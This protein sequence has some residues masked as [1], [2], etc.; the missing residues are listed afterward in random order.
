[1]TRRLRLLVA[2]AVAALLLS[3]VVAGCGA[4]GSLVATDN[5]LHNLG[6]QSVQV[7][8]KPE[9]NSVDASV[10]VNATP[11]QANA[12]DVAGVV[13]S[14]FHE[15][16]DYLYVTVHGNGPDVR[17]QYSFE[18]MVQT[19]GPRNPAWNRTSVKGGITRIG[20]GVIVALAVAAL[21]VVGIILLVQ[22]RN[23]RR[24]PP[25]PGGPGWGG[26][27]W[28]GPGGP[29]SG[30]PGAGAW[31]QGGSGGAGGPAVGYPGPYGPRPGYSPPG[32]P[33]HPPPGW[34][35]PAGA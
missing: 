24:K 19:F 4:I 2:A 6:Y 26:S 5:A 9:T 12:H 30:G 33:P 32:S 7:S 15:S 1:M 29:G 27:G 34:G 3:G 23:R 20:A 18:Q 17:Q 21:L 10:K 14:T 25:W 35:P 28:G 31:G 16:F 8:P 22:R 11:T 13:W